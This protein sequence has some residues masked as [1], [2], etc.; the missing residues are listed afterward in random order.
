MPL[1]VVGKG[2]LG[3]VTVGVMGAYEMAPPDRREQAVFLE[4]LAARISCAKEIPPE[5]H[6][7]LSEMLDRI[8]RDRT[9]ASRYADLEVRRQQA[10]AGLENIVRQAS[11]RPVSARA[12]RDCR[13]SAGEPVLRARAQHRSSKGGSVPKC[14]SEC[15]VSVRVR[16]L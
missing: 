15:F 2:L 9:R 13:G 6:K 11:L 16:L 5:T 1:S 8:S 4:R 12:S 3:I 10:I 14:P 7:A